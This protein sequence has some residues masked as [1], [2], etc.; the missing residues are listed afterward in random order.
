[1]LRAR[2]LEPFG[3]ALEGLDLSSPLPA[4]RLAEIATLAHH[5]GVLLF[6][7]QTLDETQQIAFSR[8]L[9]PL[10]QHPEKLKQQAAHPEIF[11]LSN[12]RDDGRLEDPLGTATER[13]HT[14]SSYRAIPCTLSILYAVEVP[15]QGGDTEF[16][17]ACQ[18]WDRLAADRRAPLEDLRV[19]HS[20]QHSS[21]DSWEN[22]SPAEREAVPPVE[23]PLVRRLDDGRRALYLGSHASHVVG[24]DPG[25]ELLRELL[26]HTTDP[27]L[28]YRHRWQP[29]DLL[30]WDNRVTLHRRL[31]YRRDAD[32]RVMRRTTVCGTQAPRC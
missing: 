21:P 15:G 4:D 1:M 18:A 9:G 26:E 32:R 14:D 31:P 30:I 27:A 12:V 5:H 8:G 25:R 3:G 29:G 28:V 17:N 22:M 24:P 16:A 23:H 20:Y 2:P 6:R 19:V 10:E 11:D 7:G 13:W